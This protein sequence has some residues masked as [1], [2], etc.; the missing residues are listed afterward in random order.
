MAK[1]KPAEESVLDV[2]TA[3]DELLHV[4]YFRSLVVV[5]TTHITPEE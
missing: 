3:F 2:I 1:N 5:S 4:R